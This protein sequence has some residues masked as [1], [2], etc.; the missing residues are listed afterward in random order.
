[1][2]ITRWSEGDVVAYDATPDTDSCPCALRR[3]ERSLRYD[4]TARARRPYGCPRRSCASL[5]AAHARSHHAVLRCPDGRS[6]HF[7]RWPPLSTASA[8]PPGRTRPGRRLSRPQATGAGVCDQAQPVRCWVNGLRPKNDARW[9]AANRTP[10][11][12]GE[13]GEQQEVSVRHVGCL[14]CGGAKTGLAA[15][16]TIDH[17]CRPVNSACDLCGGEG[18]VSVEARERWHKGR[19]MRDTRVR[20]RAQ[21]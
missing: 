3:R 12:C 17:G 2:K 21:H 1:M 13:A 6:A 14:S 16:C 11:P 15:A 7:N 19:S 9:S 8:P 20:G 4:A 18:Q 10:C 5:S